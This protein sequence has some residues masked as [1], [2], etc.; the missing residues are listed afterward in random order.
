MPEHV[1]HRCLALCRQAHALEGDAH[2]QALVELED[3]L[4]LATTLL[5]AQ[6]KGLQSTSPA[7]ADSIPAITMDPTGYIIGWNDGATRLFGYSA[8]EAVGQHVLFLYADNGGGEVAE[9]DVRQ[10]QSVMEVRRR[11]KS[12]QIFRAN[13]SLMAQRDAAGNPVSL[14]ARLMEIRD[15]LTTEERVRLHARIFEDSDQ[16]IM[17]VDADEHVVSVNPAFTHITGYTAAESIGHTADILRSGKHTAN[18]RKEVRAA[19]HGS[20][21]WHGEIV[22]RRKNGELF[23]QSVTIGVI[24]ND[25]GRITHAFSIF[26]DISAHKEA[27]AR[28]ANYDS[29]TKLP[30]RALFDQLVSQALLAARRNDGH[31][32]VLVIGPHRFTSINDTLGHEAGD[33][34]LRQ[35]SLRFRKALRDEDV[36]ARVDGHR[37]AVALLDIQKREH[38]GLVAQKLIASL[39]APIMIGG[40]DLRV[41]LAVGIAVYP[42]D[43]M[44]TATLLR[45]ADSAMS[46]VKQNGDTAYLFFSPEMNQRAKEHLWFESELR[47]ALIGDQLQLHYQPKVSLRSGRIVGAEALIRWRHP[48]RGMIAPGVFIAI[49]EETGLILDIGAW[50][51][52][53]AC[54]QIRRWMDTGIDAPPIAVNLSSRQFDRQ[55]PQRIQAVLDR[56]NVSPERLKLEITESLLVRGPEKVI[57]IMNELAAMGLALALDDFGTGYSSL[58]YLK[59]FPISTLKIDRAFVIGLPKEEND[60]AIAQAIVTMGQQLRQEIVAEGVETVEQM[61]FLRE[62]GC[63]QLQGY[64][65]S[66]PVAADEFARMVREGKRLEFNRVP[67]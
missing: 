51:L 48:E 30:T 53:E 4:K 20:G 31:G 15:G 63:D 60:C 42:E 23:P 61:S 50:V 45:F 36:L 67:S 52:E 1:I 28:M 40:H 27:Q 62:L 29:L 6:G 57:P 34:L 54:R 59:K 44:E 55:L 35:M 24:R 14:T 47:R 56:H 19:M 26:T 8:E 11:K 16:G 58:A 46:K 18:F 66:P 39:A 10:K 64:L 38:A 43:G 32:A 22:G 33:E 5:L 65:F 49:A 21:P 41:G 3:S 17:I 13:L 2:R 12:G 9:L 7:E 25:A 37:F